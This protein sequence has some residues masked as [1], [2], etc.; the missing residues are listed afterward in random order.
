MNRNPKVDRSF[1][2]A[3]SGHP[4][5]AMLL[6]AITQQADQP[7]DEAI[8]EHLERCPSCC[9]RMESMATG[10]SGVSDQMAP[11]HASDGDI[12]A[13][14]CNALRRETESDRSSAEIGTSAEFRHESI[15]D[16]AVAF[17]EPTDRVGAIGRLGGFEILSVIGH[18]G[19]GIV[20]KGF[21]EELNRP[22]AVKIMSP[23]LAT[24]A[25]ARKRFLREAQA[26]AAVVH[27][28]VMPILSVS[29]SSSLPFL[30]MPFVACHSLQQRLDVDGP[31]PLVDSLRIALQVAQGLAAAHAQGLVHRDVKPANILL[32]RG[33]DRAMLTDF[34]LARAADDATV[35]RSGVIAGTPQYM[36]PEQARGGAIDARSD[37][38]SLGSVIHA[39]IIGRP[40][41]RA[42]TSY[43]ILRK[44]TDATHQP[45]RDQNPM[46]PVWLERLVDRL[47]SKDPADRPATAAELADTLEACLAH[48]QQP[49]TFP[50]PNSLIARS[51]SP[52]MSRTLK[53]LLVI[54]AGLLILPAVMWITWGLSHPDGNAKAL[55]P[56]AA[57]RV[58]P[59]PLAIVNSPELVEPID[60]DETLEEELAILTNQINE[61]LEETSP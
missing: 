47:L 19:M 32:E 23:H 10:D 53:I 17:L 39:M 43:G 44:I 9:H 18:G 14:I 61:L 2:W 12:A 56:G 8:A 20:L 3:Q 5:D 60:S 55:N 34:G 7:T 21:Q 15:V 49:T 42:E 27:P 57:K 59:F 13:E 28:N 22:V 4:T 26:T 54:L 51:W 37:L 50:L 6:A 30:V 25:L 46:I 36:S 31:L 11:E 1:P 48:V 40:P 29:E 16:F 24:I 58:T 45:L 33:I 52:L 35:T 38:F 41:F